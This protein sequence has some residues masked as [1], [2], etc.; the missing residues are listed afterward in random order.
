MAELKRQMDGSENQLSAT[1]NSSGE[2]NLYKT[3]S[4]SLGRSTSS[5]SSKDRWLLPI[6]RVQASMISSLACAII[7]MC[8]MYGFFMISTHTSPST[9]IGLIGD[10]RRLSHTV[11]SKARQIEM[12]LTFNMSTE[13]I[14]DLQKDL[15][16]ESKKINN[17]VK[18]S[19]LNDAWTS[20]HVVNA[21]GISDKRMVVRDSYGVPSTFIGNTET[22]FSM[23]GSN[24]FSL[25]HTD[26]ET[27]RQYANDPPVTFQRGVPSKLLAHSQWAFIMDNG[28]V[29]VFDATWDLLDAQTNSNE[30]AIGGDRKELVI[31]G[32][33]LT[34]NF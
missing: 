9:E 22:M 6:K 30:A 32:V 4:R 25:G 20:D 33:S 10:V 27:L 21:W 18:S 11:A 14:S 29:P 1:G 24:A 31:L 12:A 16:T 26:L 8:V 3:L 28:F 17:V 23:F 13:S 34:C 5:K 15:I 19:R 7:T 2:V